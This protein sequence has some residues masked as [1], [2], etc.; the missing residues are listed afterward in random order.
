MNKKE[1]EKFISSI[2]FII[3]KQNNGSHYWIL[4]DSEFPNWCG[5][6]VDEDQLQLHNSFR[7]PDLKITYLNLKEENLKEKIIN[8]FVK[9]IGEIPKSFLNFVREE[10]IKTIL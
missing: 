3:L 4:S 5:L 7:L 1:L 9:E 6:L 8:H 2:G 10:K